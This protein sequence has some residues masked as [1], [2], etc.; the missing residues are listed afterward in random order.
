MLTDMMLF[1]NPPKPNFEQVNVADML[2]EVIAEAAIQYPDRAFR[3][4]F[5]RIGKPAL[6]NVDRIQIGELAAALIRNSIEALSGEG[7][8][9]VT[10]DESHADCLSIRVE[11]T[12]SGIDPAILPYVFDPFFSGRE[13]GRG[14]GFG[15]S[16]AWTIARLHGGEVQCLSGQAGMTV[17][18][19]T[20]PLSEICEN[21]VPVDKEAAS[22][23]ANTFAA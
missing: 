10:L 21:A 2:A 16:K 19:A 15:L 11:D 13:A 22:S 4:T 23:S 3:L 14:L 1:A 9:R 8:V 17:F 18:E 6:W 12:G 5:A 7:D 20:F